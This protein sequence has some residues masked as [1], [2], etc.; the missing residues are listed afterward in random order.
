MI[1]YWHMFPNSRI[2]D[3]LDNYKNMDA[4]IWQAFFKR[5]IHKPIH[6][7]VW[8][9]SIQARKPQKWLLKLWSIPYELNQRFSLDEKEREWYTNIV[10]NR[11]QLCHHRIRPLRCR[12]WPLGIRIP[13]YLLTLII[14][15]C[16]ND[17]LNSL[18]HLRWIL[19]SIFIK[20]RR[21]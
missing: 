7:K 21:R 9:R 12:S 2:D 13:L 19:Q 17:R 14:W 1:W 10:N 16:F 8:R 15:L 3:H 6:S 18:F 11:C 5:V 20:W 4:N